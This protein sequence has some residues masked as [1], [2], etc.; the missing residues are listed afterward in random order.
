MPMCDLVSNKPT[1]GLFMGIS[2]RHLLQG[3]PK[4]SIELT[5]AVS[6]ESKTK[7]NIATRFKQ[8]LKWF[9]GWSNET[10]RNSIS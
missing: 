3:Y 1:T 9:W 2:A 5:R 10:T 7:H 8:A 6:I 4:K